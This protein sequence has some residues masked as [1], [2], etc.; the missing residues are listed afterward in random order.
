LQKA[1]LKALDGARFIP[2]TIDHKPAAVDFHGTV[3]F[4]PRQKP[5]LRVFTNQDRKE[6]ARFADF[7]A[8]QL[9]GGSTKF[10][11]KDPALE[12]ARR[13]KKDGSA[14]LAGERER[15]VARIANHLGGTVRLWLWR[16]HS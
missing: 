6:L 12:A 4:F 3:M 9:I 7:V 15:R 1:V 5:N 2:A 8:P 13:M 16:C 10:D 14:V 11:G